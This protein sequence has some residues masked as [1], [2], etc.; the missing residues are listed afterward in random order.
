MTPS[1]NRVFIHPEAKLC[2]QESEFSYAKPYTPLTRD[3][4][5]N[6][7]IIVDTADKADFIFIGQ[8]N[9]HYTLP[10]SIKD[11]CLANPEK[12]IVDIEGDF[13]QSLFDPCLKNT[14]TCA[15]GP[16]RSW[17]LSKCFVR[18]QL[19]KV[20]IEL[21]LNSPK[22]T[23]PY[24]KKVAFFFQGQINVHNRVV[25]LQCL[26]NINYPKSV[27]V[28]GGWSGNKNIKDSDYCYNMDH[29]LISICPKG[30][31]GSSIRFYES[32]YFG[33][34]IVLLGNDCLLGEDH[35]DMSFIQRTSDYNNPVE[36]TKLLEGITKKSKEELY[37]LGSKSRR[38]YQ[39]VVKPYLNDPM[40]SFKDWMKL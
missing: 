31:G 24:Q 8:V 15:G 6:N 33:C 2:S 38:Y 1:R 21:Y 5:Q 7:F 23:L 22:I 29:N 16:D 10:K 35:Y 40:K 26:Q 12:I 20:F 4:I 39:E 25:M 30:V 11:I 28:T 19:S 37:D 17:G 9:E 34:V 36:V 13:G 32:C 18:P 14:I 3:K 27:F